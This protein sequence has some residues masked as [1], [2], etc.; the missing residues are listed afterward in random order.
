MAIYLDNAATTKPAPAVLRAVSEC[1]RRCYGNPSSL[2]RLGVE[3]ARTVER[4][5]A[6]LAEALGAE[7]D[8]IVFTSGGTESNNLALKGALGAAGKRGA[9]IVLSA[10]EHPSV[11]AAARALS[12]L[13]RRV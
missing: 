10:V 11:A 2:H 13:L 9:H 5:R 6:V 1:A 7:P 12:R 3:A 8:E 4:S